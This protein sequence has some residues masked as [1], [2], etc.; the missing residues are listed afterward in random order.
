M[1]LDVAKEY[2]FES[3]SELRCFMNMVMIIKL[4]LINNDSVLKDLP[5]G[6]IVSMLFP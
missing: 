4:I 5:H 2:A 6:T 1:T 3:F